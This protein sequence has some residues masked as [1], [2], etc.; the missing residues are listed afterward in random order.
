MF[1]KTIYFVFVLS[2][3]GNIYCGFDYYMKQQDKRH[4]EAFIENRGVKNISLKNG[5]DFLF[6]KIK[7]SYPEYQKTK[8]YYFISIWNTLCGPCIKE[9]QLLDSLADNIDRKDF[10]YIFVTENS[11]NMINQFL[12]KRNISSKNFSFINDADIY[13]SSILKSHNLKTRQYP[14]Q[15]I[16]DDKGA[17]KYFQ[18]GV[19]ESSTDSVVMKC[20][21]DL[22]E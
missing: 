16:I 21:K 18:I 11:D 17:I 4:L 3:G 20:V 7:T 13:I 12:K 15:L 19:F 1:R 9:M 22:K 6:E 8:K 5:S 10:R 14:I 2:I